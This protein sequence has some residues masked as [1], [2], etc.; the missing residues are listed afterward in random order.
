MSTQHTGHSPDKPGSPPC[1]SACLFPV[2]R[3]PFCPSR[4]LGDSPGRLHHA[5][6]Q[7]PET[8]FAMQIATMC[9]YVCVRA[10]VC[11]CVCVCVKTLLEGDPLE[12]RKPQTL[13][14]NS[15]ETPWGA[16]P[17][18][19]RPEPTP[20]PPPPRP[21]A[22]DKPQHQ[23]AAHTHSGAQPCSRP[24]QLPGFLTEWL[25]GQELK[26]TGWTHSS[27]GLPEKPPTDSP[28]RVPL[29]RPDKNA[30]DG[31]HPSNHSSL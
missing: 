11:V 19:K 9:V 4:P 13:K 1:C 29:C 21:T 20:A 15:Q 18:T 30:P 31:F 12:A 25:W 7:T 27:S 5:L 3:T 26:D 28:T 17:A 24:A 16:S 8:T 22:T 23:L 6:L 10:C 2:P 14:E